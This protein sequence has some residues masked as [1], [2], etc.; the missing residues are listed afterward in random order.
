MEIFDSAAKEKLSM[1]RTSAFL[2]SREKFRI[3]SETENDRE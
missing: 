2:N 1:E 3:L